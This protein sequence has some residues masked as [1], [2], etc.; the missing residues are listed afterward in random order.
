VRNNPDT[1]REVLSRGHVIGNHSHTHPLFALKSPAFIEDEFTQAQIAI[2]EVTGF[3]P[4][5]VRAPYGVRWAGF[6]P[7]QEKL[8]L[9]GVMWT[10][11]GRDWRLSAAEIA[12]RVVARATNGGIVCLHDGR[13]IRSNP[14][15]TPSIE[16]VRR[17][18]PALLE[19]GYH[20]ET[21]PDLLCPTN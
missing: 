4:S 16:A 6:R 5:L 7:M 15:I 10:V 12:H 20:F 3:S 2:E 14:D 11:I 13:G 19:A 18:I 9:T 21:V 17:I 8:G 1:A